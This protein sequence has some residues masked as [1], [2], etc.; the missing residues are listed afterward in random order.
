MP[1]KAGFC[2]IGF[3]RKKNPPLIWYLK[4]ISI[5]APAKMGPEQG[6]NSLTYKL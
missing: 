2:T 6:K 4:T 5:F 3:M 1:I